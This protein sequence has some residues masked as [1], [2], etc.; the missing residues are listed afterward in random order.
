MRKS[1]LILFSL[2]ITA[3]SLAQEKT[4]DKIVAKVGSTILLQSDVENQ[5]QQYVAQGFPANDVTRCRLLEELL[6]QKLLVNQAQV[7]S[8]T[9]SDSQV[10]S[11]LDRRMRY[12]ISQI[13]SEEKLEEYYKKPIVEIKAE[14]SDLI[15]DQLLAQTMQSKIT[16]NVKATPGDVRSYFENIPKDSL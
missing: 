14:F 2:F 4:L 15:R 8:V 5:Y 16:E 1:I 12:F 6:F 13:G 3:L 9:V 11:E 7:D 10:E